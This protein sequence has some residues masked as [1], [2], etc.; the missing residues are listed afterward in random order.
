MG[1]E[2]KEIIV[3]IIKTSSGNKVKISKKEWTNIGNKTGWI[4]E[5]LGPPK[6]PQ[7]GF[8]GHGLSDEAM[9]LLWQYDIGPDQ[10]FKYDDPNSGLQDI[11]QGIQAA[12]QGDIESLRQALE[13]RFGKKS[14]HQ[15]KVL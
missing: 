12:K 9:K 2:S 11:Y 7:K 4:K 5:A 14:W 13:N 6:A 1:T 8:Y 3:K 10:L 15:K